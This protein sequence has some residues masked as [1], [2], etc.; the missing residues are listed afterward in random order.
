MIT[1]VTEDLPRQYRALRSIARYNGD[2]TTETTRLQCESPPPAAVSEFFPK[3][4]GI[5]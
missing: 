3:Q 1:K 5:F 2:T 4:M